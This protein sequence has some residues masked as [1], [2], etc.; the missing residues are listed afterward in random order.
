MIIIMMIN[1]V[2]YSYFPWFASLYTCFYFISFSFWYHVATLHIS[3]N[4]VYE[5]LY[6]NFIRLIGTYD[7]KQS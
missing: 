3:I 2:E 4:A 7:F 6:T 5:A 1:A